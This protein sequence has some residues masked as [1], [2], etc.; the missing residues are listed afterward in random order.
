MNDHLIHFANRSV[1]FD[2]LKHFLDRHRDAGETLA[3]ML[4]NI[5]RFRR[6][7]T[8]F[9]YQVGDELL[10]VFA[11]RLDNISR[12]KDYIARMGN[13][14]FLLV[15]PQIMNAGHATLAAHK[16]LNSLAEN[17]VLQNSEHKIT[18]HIGVSLFPEHAN[19][20][21]ELMQKAEI[22][23]MSA[24]NSAQ[25][26]AVY[27][28]EN[29]QFDVSAWDIEG[30][31]DAA[32]END[33][34]ELYY[35]P[36]ISIQTGIVF[37]A[38][39]LIRWNNKQRGFIRPEIF[40]SMAEHSGHINAITWWT[41]NRALREV[42]EWPRAWKPLKVAVNVSA[43]IL[44]DIAFVDSVKSALSIWGVPAA[45]LTLEITESTLMEDTTSSIITL[46]ELKTLGVGI[47][48]DD[49]GTGYSSMA[50][51]KN[52][53]ANELKIDQSFVFYMLKNDMDM[54]VVNTIIELAHGF[55][56]KV[57]AEGVENKETYVVLKELDCDIAQGFYLAKPMPQAEFIKWLENYE[58]QR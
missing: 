44:K 10:E 1:L 47:S 27:T 25:A 39:A 52:I 45:Q 6:L 11:N 18:A 21:S 3:I 36:Q 19:D 58:I 43:L 46:E 37:G 12:D 50:Y 55:N 17:F 54:H 30:D 48:I 29:K 4:I 15:L 7:N 20:V 14:E 23:L 40:I 13:S 28:D 2:D 26:F 31:L 56:L 33:E 35:Q 24:R 5:D 16:I 32:L 41:L 51:F 53:P 8:V 34:F 42:L 38:E 22:A 9:G 57:V 49:F